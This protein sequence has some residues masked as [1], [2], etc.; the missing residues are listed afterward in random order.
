[1]AIHLGNRLG[2]DFGSEMDLRADLE[3]HLLEP[4]QREK[5]DGILETEHYLHNAT[6]VGAVLR[7]IV[8]CRGQHGGF[9]LVRKVELCWF[10]WR[11]KMDAPGPVRFFFWHVRTD[12]IAECR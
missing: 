6:A 5:F 4:E 3:V 12:S 1:M 2:V 8:T 11:Y 9:K 7:Y 10:F